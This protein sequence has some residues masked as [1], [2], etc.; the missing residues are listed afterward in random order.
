MLSGPKSGLANPRER[1]YFRVSL[2]GV[3]GITERSASSTS[4][5]DRLNPVKSPTDSLDEAKP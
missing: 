4:P 1:V 3:L 2:C 5:V